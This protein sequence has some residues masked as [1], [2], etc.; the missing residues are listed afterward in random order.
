MPAQLILYPQIYNGTYTSTGGVIYSQYVA[1]GNFSTGLQFVTNT[2]SQSSPA[3]FSLTVTGVAINAWKGFYSSGG[4]WGSGNS[5][6]TI[7]T[8][9][10]NLFSTTS[11]FQTSSSGAYQLISN[12]TVGQ[13]YEVQITISNGSLGTLK[14]GN[15]LNLWIANS[16]V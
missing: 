1:D 10:L 4:S 6:P 12:L 8:N 11:L 3:N 14:I 5:T 13:C 7:T 15:S 16:V 2:G 9:G